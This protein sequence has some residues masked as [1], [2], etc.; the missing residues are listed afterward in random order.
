M[1]FGGKAIEAVY[2]DSQNR[3]SEILS[4]PLAKICL[5]CFPGYFGVWFVSIHALIHPQSISEALLGQH[6]PGLKS[7]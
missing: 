7:I 6:P 4:A 1:I 5:S 2:D 3:P